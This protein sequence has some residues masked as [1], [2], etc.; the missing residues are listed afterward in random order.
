M[1]IALSLAS[2]PLVFP[3]PSAIAQGMDADTKEAKTLFEDGVKLYKTG[4]FEEARVKFKAAY[5]LKKRPS[6]V[7]N[8]AR[9]EM[10]TKRQL[11][12]IAHFKE[13]IA[14]ADAKPEDKDE[15]KADL[16]EARK[17]VGVVTVDAPTGTIVTI[18]GE[19]RAVPAD[20]AIELLPGPHTIV[21]KTAG[22]DIVQKV[23]LTAGQTI[24]VKSKPDA[25][26][27]STAPPVA[28]AAPAPTDTPPLPTA[29]AAPTS[30]P[31][32]PPPETGR[33]SFVSTIHPVS[34]VTAGVTVLGAVG[35][36]AFYATSQTHYANADRFA[37]AFQ[38]PTC[39]TAESAGKSCTSA[40]NKASYKEQGIAELEAGDSNKSLA[41]VFGVVTLLAATATVVTLVVLRKKDEPR[42]ALIGAP[43]I[44]GGAT[45]SLVGRF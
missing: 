13:V 43:M 44:G 41:L 12:A 10:Q 28:T 34:Y 25:A 42:V 21:L 33:R 8:L 18:D 31:E 17:Q 29:T 5:G 24:E 39:G 35:W 16:A 2:A 40:A 26:P 14:M 45:F 15:A 22:K 32:P 4:K 9:A 36:I 6:I 19:S 37:E 20:G 7:L 1:V 30:T 23:D 27:V 11:D 3:L 38:R